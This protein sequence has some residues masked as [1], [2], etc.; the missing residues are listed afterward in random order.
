MGPAFFA[1]LSLYGEQLDSTFHQDAWSHLRPRNSRAKE[2]LTKTSD[3]ETQEKPFFFQKACLNADIPP[4]IP[5]PAT[6]SRAIG[7]A[8]AGVVQVKIICGILGVM[9]GQIL[10]QCLPPWLK[11]ACHIISS[12]LAFRVTLDGHMYSFVTFLGDI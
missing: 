9:Q 2:P 10:L 8:L 1:P 12:S 5:S 3:A 6:L 11:A 4:A 7:P